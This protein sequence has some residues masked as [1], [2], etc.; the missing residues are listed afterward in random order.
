M[1]GPVM[2]MKVGHTH[3][4]H[5]RSDARDKFV[6]YTADTGFGQ[7][8]TLTDDGELVEIQ[9]AG[10]SPGWTTIVPFGDDLLFY[11]K[12]DG[13]C[14]VVTFGGSVSLFTIWDTFLPSMRNG[15]RVENLYPYGTTQ[16][17]NEFHLNHEIATLRISLPAYIYIAV[18]GGLWEPITVSLITYPDQ[19][20]GEG[21]YILRDFAGIYDSSY[22]SDWTFM[23]NRNSMIKYQCRTYTQDNPF[24]GGWETFALF[25]EHPFVSFDSGIQV[26]ASSRE[27]APIPGYTIVSGT[28]DCLLFYEERTGD[29]TTG[30]IWRDANRYHGK[31]VGLSTFRLSAQWTHIVGTDRQLVFYNSDTGIV[32]TGYLTS[33]GN[34]IQQQEG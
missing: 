23:A 22:D 6:F 7:T 3:M 5:F 34:F 9:D 30:Y 10:L 2:P 25:R 18:G 29:C 21:F 31:I 8:V 12:T 27:L 33:E 32:A 1:K 26:F 13:Y 11:R 4:A 19:L 28:R 17:L 24:G 15:Q 16:V 20:A 14:E